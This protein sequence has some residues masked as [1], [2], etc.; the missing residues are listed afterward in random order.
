MKTLLLKNLIFTLFV[1]G[2]VEFTFSQSYDQNVL[3]QNIQLRIKEI[4]R[5]TDS[6]STVLADLK[7]NFEKSNSVDAKKIQ[8]FKTT[9]K[10]DSI[11]RLQFITD[12]TLTS[13]KQQITFLEILQN[14]DNLL[15]SLLKGKAVSLQAPEPIYNSNSL[16]KL[17]ITKIK[18]DVNHNNLSSKGF[19]IKSETSELIL[20]TF[21][22]EFLNEYVSEI[23]YYKSQLNSFQ[24]EQLFSIN[25]D[26]FESKSIEN[27]RKSIGVEDFRVSGVNLMMLISY[28]TYTK[29]RKNGGSTK[30][31]IDNLEMADK[32]MKQGDY[33]A[34]WFHGFHGPKVVDWTAS[35]TFNAKGEI[36]YKNANFDCYYRNIGI[37][38]RIINEKQLIKIQAELTNNVLVKLYDQTS[39]T[40]FWEDF[41]REIKIIKRHL[42]A[43][44]E[45]RT[46]QSEIQL[47]NEQKKTIDLQVKNLNT[48]ISKLES[49]LSQSSKSQKSKI[50]EM[51]RIIESKDKRVENAK[52][53]EKSRLAYIV[54]GDSYLKN[55]DFEAAI[56]SFK[57]AQ[58]IRKSSDLVEKIQIAEKKYAPILAKKQEEETQ[59]N[60]EIEA[61]R[62]KENE[63][64]HSE[65]VLKNWLLEAPFYNYEKTVKVEFKQEYVENFNIGS[66]IWVYVNGNKEGELIKYKLRGSPH[67]T[68]IDIK[69]I[70]TGKIESVINVVSSSEKVMKSKRG[71]M[72]GIGAIK[73]GSNLRR[74]GCSFD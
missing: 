47:L 23:P 24:N 13:N 17:D 74:E 48:S 67:N 70:R 4:N 39:T 44:V 19:K 25:Y 72:T 37:G 22:Q 20:E 9:E 1:F 69:W 60:R 49:T 16:L 40:K 71:S 54:N 27:L 52:E 38:G 58:A 12:S 32:K 36:K 55:N 10:Y 68:F 7:R 31:Y 61:N 3:N 51:T 46:L 29:W 8:D 14:R 35:I 59:R 33:I 34:V 64:W 2:F 65:D 11:I 18:D 73:N 62:L 43:K 57:N 21:Y 63:D 50:D 53:Q 66:M 6:L 28:E 45:I 41:G 15:D 30:Y 26:D 5:E 42:N 56:S